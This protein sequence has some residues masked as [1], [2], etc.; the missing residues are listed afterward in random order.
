[1]VLNGAGWGQELDTPARL[2]GGVFGGLEPLHRYNLHFTEGFLR[3]SRYKAVT[4][5]LQ[6]VTKRTFK[7][8]ASPSTMPCARS[9]AAEIATLPPGSQRP[10]TS[11][12]YDASAVGP[13]NRGF[14][15]VENS[16]TILETG[17]SGRTRTTRARLFGNK[18]RCQPGH[19][20]KNLM[21]PV[22]PFLR[23]QKSS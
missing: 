7:C 2:G 20:P 9:S 17:Q 16:K 14:A 6:A 13:P 4:R 8:S 19:Q 22:R 10:L 11:T 15:N 1:M 18:I 3:S 5:A 12:Q 21:P 23:C